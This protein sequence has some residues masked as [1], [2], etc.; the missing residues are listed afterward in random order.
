M[1]CRKFLGENLEQCSIEEL[2]S[3]EVKL[4]RS[5]HIIRRK[6]VI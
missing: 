1:G 2:H 6:K 5:I 3:L 4:E